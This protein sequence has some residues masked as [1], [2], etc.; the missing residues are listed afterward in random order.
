MGPILLFLV[1]AFVLAGCGGKS[2]PSA[3]QS[4]SPTTGLQTLAGLEPPKLQVTHQAT[5]VADGLV[6]LAQKG[7]KQSRKG[8]L[9][10]ADNRGR[11]RWF[12]QL[13]EPDEATD[14]RTQ[15]YRGRPV[16]TWWQG[17]SSKAG[18][19]VGSYV[20]YDS[21]YRKIAAVK[22]GHGLSGDL[23]EF[24]LTPRGT[25]YVTVYNEVPRDLSS[26]GGP[27]DGWAYD[28][29]VQEID[30]AS[31]KVVLE[32]HSLDHVPLAESLQA[33]REPAHNATNKRPLDYFHVNSIAD[34]PGGRILISARN[35]SALYLLARDGSIVWRLGGKRSNFGPP[36]AVKFRYQHDA[37]LHP[38]NLLT[39]FDNGGI[40]RAEP[41]SRPLVL[42]LDEHAHRATIIK[43]FVHPDKIASP[44]EGN[45]EL[46][47]DG[48]AFVGWGG[49]RKLT[50]FTPAGSVR[51][52]LK[53]P[54]GDTYRGYRLPWAGKPHRKPLA[55]LRGDTVYASWN[56][57]TT[58]MRW[59]VLA[60]SDSAHLKQ[61]AEGAWGGL[62]T[63]I[64][65]ATSDPVVAVRAVDSAGHE[66]G[67]SAS[68]ER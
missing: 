32:W 54:F 37:R 2:K 63:A 34:A 7:G 13:V 24:Q 31:G 29:V 64:P 62:E 21:S 36:A 42:R 51:F 6:F 19:G 50:E 25:A 33:G 28:S 49:V 18:V 1:L 35:T 15:T 65:I 45:L 38:G 67:T 16:L 8:G 66:L 57:S 3:V 48:G 44:F 26:V 60:G 5:G 43:T 39:L 53:L 4:Q 10:I 17:S 52:E 20:I 68:I 61:V 9:V 14:F 22:A 40:P 55:A 30:I 23:H 12:H 41:F 11:I 27:K 59:Q 56:G 58:T 47:P 46:L